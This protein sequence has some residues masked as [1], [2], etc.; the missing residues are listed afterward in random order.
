MATRLI[1]GEALLW[2]SSLSL[3]LVQDPEANV[4][5]AQI[6]QKL[7]Q[8]HLHHKRLPFNRNASRTRREY[9]LMRVN[10]HK[11]A[12][13]PGYVKRSPTRP[14]SKQNK[15]RRNLDKILLHNS[16]LGYKWLQTTVVMPSYAPLE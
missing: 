12:E 8:L 11:H 9:A 7:T 5:R 10:I 13:L 2:S 4:L 16:D 6:H 15:L 1:T 3:S 14:G